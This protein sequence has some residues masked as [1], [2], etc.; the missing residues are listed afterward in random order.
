[1]KFKVNMKALECLGNA[2]V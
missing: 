2:Y 1:M